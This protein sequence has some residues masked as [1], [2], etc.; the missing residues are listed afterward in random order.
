MSRNAARARGTTEVVDLGLLRSC[1]QVYNEA[2]FIPYLTNTFSCADPR[3]LQEF[4]LSTAQGT[5][6]NHLAIR[7]LFLDMVYDDHD[8]RSLWKIAISTCVR[9]LKALHKVSISIDMRTWY[10]ISYGDLTSD[11]KR[12]RDTLMSTIRGLKRLPLK[13]VTMVISDYGT[14][15]YCIRQGMTYLWTPYRY[16][17]DQKRTWVRDLR[18][19]ILP[20]NRQ[21]LEL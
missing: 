17:L 4:V 10:F 16:T 7:S 20:L 11:G 12:C 15:Q 19:Y 21:E 2:H 8:C 1:R 6:S 5:K 9:K 13:T 3:T 18:E 14:D